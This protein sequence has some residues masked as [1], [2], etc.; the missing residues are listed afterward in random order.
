MRLF[1]RWKTRPDVQ[2]LHAASGQM[3]GERLNLALRCLSMLQILIN[4]D[5]TKIAA[6]RHVASDRGS[7]EIRSNC[8]NLG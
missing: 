4:P 3:S 8:A 2:F 6:L 1:E 7:S 5:S